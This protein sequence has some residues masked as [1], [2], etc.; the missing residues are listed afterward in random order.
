MT[1]T[2]GTDTNHNGQEASM[3][4]GSIV[5]DTPAQ[6]SGWVYMSAVS[7]LSSEISTRTN[8]YGKRSVYSGIR[9]RIIPADMIGARATREN[10]ILALTMLCWEQE[11]SPVI[12][13]ARAVLAEVTA[14]EGIIVT[15]V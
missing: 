9:G 13:R 11:P 6:M 15:I 3:S 5:L 14:T 10:K 4:E 2:Q 8:W 12:D 7:Q 1:Q